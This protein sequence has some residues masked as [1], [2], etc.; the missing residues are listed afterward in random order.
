MVQEDK[1]SKIG[2]FGTLMCSPVSPD[3][4]T[5]MPKNQGITHFYCQNEVNFYPNFQVVVFLKEGVKSS[6]GFDL[7]QI[8]LKKRNNAWCQKVKKFETQKLQNYHF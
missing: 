6:I 3:S 2:Q 8:G 7:Y 1:V 4:R 5:T